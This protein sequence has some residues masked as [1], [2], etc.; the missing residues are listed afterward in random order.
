MTTDEGQ[1]NPNGQKLGDIVRDADEYYDYLKRKHNNQ[2]RLDVALV[3]VVVWFA[4]FAVLGVGAITT[5]SGA[6]VYDYLAGAFLVAAVIG[7]V[8]GAVMYASRRK[9]GTK[10][11]ELG[12]MIDKMKKGGA[13]SEEG[14]HLMDAMHQV[15]LVVKK[16]SLDSALEYGIVAFIV[17]VLVGR[18]A[19]IAAL[20]G[21]VAYLYFRS[22]ALHEYEK[23]V[24]R[25]ENSKKDLLQSL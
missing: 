3:T 12:A 7:A 23:E 21:V 6:S 5:I 18:N 10:F 8:A 13:S 4:A 2:T 16:R 25:Y 22:E 17:V 11:V 1:G 9:R 14:L 19:A 15:A 20:A 24:E